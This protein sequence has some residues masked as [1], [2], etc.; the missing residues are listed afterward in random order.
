MV[1]SGQDNGTSQFSSSSSI[2]NAQSNTSSP[3]GTDDPS[4][5][6]I[7]AVQPNDD[8]STNSMNVA[9]KINGVMGP[10]SRKAANG[11]RERHRPSNASTGGKASLGEHLAVFVA[12]SRQ[13]SR[14]REP[15]VDS[16]RQFTVDPSTTGESSQTAAGQGDA[17]NPDQMYRGGPGPVSVCSDSH[18]SIDDLYM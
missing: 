13:P 9:E 5:S 6:G 14:T 10:E 15:R 4:G 2:G 17:N 12:V 8:A 11:N 7:P 3:N 16:H 1:T 18:T